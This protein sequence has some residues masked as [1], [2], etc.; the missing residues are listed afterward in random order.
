MR[1]S[2]Q[3]G[4]YAFL[5]N[6]RSRTGDASGHFHIPERRC[7]RCELP[8]LD[9]L[10]VALT[11]DHLHLRHWLSAWLVSSYL[12]FLPQ[13]NERVGDDGPNAIAGR[14]GSGL[15]AALRLLAPRLCGAQILVDA[16][17]RYSWGGSV[18]SPCLTNT[19]GGRLR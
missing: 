6:P 7:G 13:V 3:S 1:L 5:S 2:P 19:R 17:G 18:S 15:T 10:N 12:L 9:H 14:N 16:R 4:P 8:V 11:V